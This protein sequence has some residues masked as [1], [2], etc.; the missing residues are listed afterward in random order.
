[1][2]TIHNLHVTTKEYEKNDLH[3]NKN[4]SVLPF[5]KP[6]LITLTCCVLHFNCQFLKSCTQ[7]LYIENYIPTVTFFYSYGHMGMDEIYV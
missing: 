1:M 2:A 5:L 6:Y 4:F 7:P 3:T